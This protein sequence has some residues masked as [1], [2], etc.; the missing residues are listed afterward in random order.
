MYLSII[1][2][3]LWEKGTVFFQI[4]CAILLYV[5]FPVWLLAGILDIAFR[6]KDKSTERDIRESFRDIL[7]GDTDDNVRA[8]YRERNA[9]FSNL[10]D[11]DLI[12][13]LNCELRQEK[14]PTLQ[15]QAVYVFARYHNDKKTTQA[16]EQFKKRRKRVENSFPEPIIPPSDHYVEKVTSEKTFFGKVATLLFS[17][18]VIF[19][20][21][22]ILLFYFVKLLQKKFQ[23]EK[24]QRENFE[25]EIRQIFI[26]NRELATKTFT[27]RHDEIVAEFKKNWHGRFDPHEHVRYCQEIVKTKSIEFQKLRILKKRFAT[28]V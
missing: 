2:S 24:I 17:I 4:I 15:A 3:S 7:S 26:R 8:I 6:R 27:E 20:L 28:L 13:S 25:R 18:T 21:S 14:E 12:A 9:R 19:L 5:F 11:K 10:W 23:Y 16:V 22:P 1:I